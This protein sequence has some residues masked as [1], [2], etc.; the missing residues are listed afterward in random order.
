MD[1]DALFG[2]LRCLKEKWA[3][4]FA[5]INIALPALMQLMLENDGADALDIDG[6]NYLSL[7]TFTAAME[8]H[9]RRA[10]GVGN[11]VKV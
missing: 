2:K 10:E 7:Q 3:V 11:V 6:T 8:P 5:F 4:V 1:L 9:I